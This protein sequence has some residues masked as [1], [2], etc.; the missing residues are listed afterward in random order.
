[1]FQTNLA[2]PTIG[3]LRSWSTIPA[4]PGDT[5]AA[6]LQQAGVCLQNIEQELA[7]LRTARGGGGAGI[8]PSPQTG[9]G[10]SV[11]V[12]FGWGGVGVVQPFGVTPATGVISGAGSLPSHIQVSP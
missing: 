5:L 3:F 9:G 2:L 12:P 4:A 6:A 8:A 7:G 10:S 11:P 1:M